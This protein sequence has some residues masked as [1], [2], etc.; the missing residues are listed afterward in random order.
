MAD[1]GYPM[2]FPNHNEEG[3]PMISGE[4]L[5]FEQELDSDPT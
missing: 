3:E 2:T 5:R 4:A 1:M